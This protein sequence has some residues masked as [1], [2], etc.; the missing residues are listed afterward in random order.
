MGTWSYVQPD[1]G[2]GDIVS[3]C[4]HAADR[5]ALNGGYVVHIRK[6]EPE[7]SLF[8]LILGTFWQSMLHVSRTLYHV[9]LMGKE[10]H[11]SSPEARLAY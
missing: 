4:S 5:G 6:F 2:P 10:K 8:A 11:L 7:L 3:A 1:L 9:S